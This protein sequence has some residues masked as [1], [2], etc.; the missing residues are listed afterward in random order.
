MEMSGDFM[1][2]VAESRC[3]GTGLVLEVVFILI[4]CR[5]GLMCFPLILLYS[6]RTEL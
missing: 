3:R 5:I 6:E 4:S 1:E 2:K